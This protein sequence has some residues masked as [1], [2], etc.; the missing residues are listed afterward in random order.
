M[1]ASIAHSAATS[2]VMLRPQRLL[3]RRLIEVIGLHVV[4][5]GESREHMGPPMFPNPTNPIRGRFTSLPSPISSSPNTTR[6]LP[7]SILNMKVTT[8]KGTG[9]KY[10]VPMDQRSRRSFLALSLS[11]L[12]WMFSPGSA[13]AAISAGSP[14]KVA[15]RERTVKGVTF[16]CRK[17]NGKLVWKRKK[18][19]TIDAVVT[20]RVL[21]SAALASGAS[22]VVE[23]A[24]SRGGST[25]VIVSRSQDG[26]S[27]FRA[28]APIKG[29]LSRALARYSSVNCTAHSL[30]PQLVL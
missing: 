16:A 22:A 27:A 29:S 19:A 1:S 9:R 12:A 4:S 11:S 5:R 21:E 30:T 13:Q 15:G 14:C 25:G 10:S 3:K 17:V 18:F 2:P 7:H 23:V 28:T 24:L 26:L 6:N 20:T 8:P